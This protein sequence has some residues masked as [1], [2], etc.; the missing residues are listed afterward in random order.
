[1]KKWKWKHIN[2]KGFFGT[3]LKF[4]KRQGI[5]SAK[6]LGSAKRQAAKAVREQ[7]RDNE[8]RGR[9]YDETGGWRMYDI[10][11][12]SNNYIVVKPA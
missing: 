12:N 6:T 8:W 7:D 3:R 2:R 4:V 10:G 9:W 11:H 5:V 1:M